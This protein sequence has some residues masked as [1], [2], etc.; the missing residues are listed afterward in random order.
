MTSPVCRKFPGLKFVFSEGGIGWLPN[1]LER[2][3]RMWD[4]HRLHSNLDDTLPSEI[5]HRNMYLCMIEEPI[6]LKY[7]ADIGVDRI[8]WECDY[9]HAD[10]VWPD[11]QMSAQSVFKEAELSEVEIAAISYGNAERV[12]NWKMASTDLLVPST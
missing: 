6:C 5:F 11:S 8:M 10:T 12:F 7:H 9:P 2:A 4:R 1:A 3:D